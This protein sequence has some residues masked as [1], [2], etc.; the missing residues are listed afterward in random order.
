MNPFSQWSERDVLLHNARVAKENQIPVKTPTEGCECESDLHDQILAE[1]RKRG[2][3]AIHSRMDKRT[4]T[5]IGVCDFI[6]L[7]DAVYH[8]KSGDYLPKIL[9]IECKTRL[10]KLS[11]AQQAFQAHAKKLGHN[12]QVVRSLQEFLLLL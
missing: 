12:V 8:S 4:T 6:I 3:L 7:R 1:C 9:L 11:P 5:A 2:W 10:G